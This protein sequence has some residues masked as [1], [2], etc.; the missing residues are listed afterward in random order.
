MK[1]VPE[2]RE[3]KKIAESGQYNV[4]PISCEILSDF[5][6]PIETMKILKNVS[7]HCY[8]NLFHVIINVGGSPGFLTP[9]L[10]PAPYAYQNRVFL[11]AGKLT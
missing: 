6:T 11:N 9:D 3:V 1:I 10:N 7:T 2:F 8:N 5:T 4:V